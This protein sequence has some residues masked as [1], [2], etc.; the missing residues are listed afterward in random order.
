MLDRLKQLGAKEFFSIP[1][2]LWLFVLVIVI[3]G[4]LVITGLIWLQLNKEVDRIPLIVGALGALFLG[5]V[6]FFNLYVNYRRTRVFEN[7]SERRD[8]QQLYTTNVD[9]LGHCSEIVRLGGIYG[10]EQLARDSTNSDRPWELKISEIL[11]AHIRTKTTSDDYDIK[12]HRRKPSNEIAAILKVLTQGENN[13]FALTQF[14]LSESNLTRAN[15]TRANLRRANLVETDLT[16]ADLVKANLGEADLTG[17]NL[18][19]AYLS[20]ADLM[21][22]NLVGANL[23]EA[24]LKGTKLE[25]AK[26]EDVDLR[27]TNLKEFNLSEFELIKVKFMGADLTGADLTEADLTG[28]DLTETDL[29]GADLTGANLTGANLTEANLTETDLDRTK[30]EKANLSKVN[31]MGRD[32]RV[33]NLTNANLTKT[34]LKRADLREADLDGANLNEANLKGANLCETNLSGVSRLSRD[35]NVWANFIGCEFDS[36]DLTGIYWG[37]L[38]QGLEDAIKRDQATGGRGNQ[39]QYLADNAD[40]QEPTQAEKEYL[41][42]KENVDKCTWGDIW[43]LQ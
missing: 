32:L 39:E 1:L 31:L 16:K 14:D 37:V 12:K 42:G 25:G 9:H 17:A 24:K 36:T 21:N 33:S 15:L 20:Q 28:A 27:K 18:K 5:I 41:V 23:S 8:H 35:R 13:P 3:C 43:V 38:T 22:A 29:T 26:L 34:N 40:R 7:T 10:L 11:C 30:L 6:G 19:G 2:K 4:I